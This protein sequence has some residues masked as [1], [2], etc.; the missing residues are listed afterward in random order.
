[1]TTQNG[2]FEEEDGRSP[3]TSVDLDKQ[4]L[5]EAD[6][7]Q[8][9]RARPAFQQVHSPQISSLFTG[10]F[11]L[12]ILLVDCC[13]RLNAQQKCADPEL[14][15]E[16]RPKPQTEKFQLQP[17]GGLQESSALS[18]MV[19]LCGDSVVQAE[20]SLKYAKSASGFYRATAQPDVHWKMVLPLFSLNE[21][22]FCP[23]LFSA[24][25]PGC[26]KCNCASFGHII[27]GLGKSKCP[28]GNSHF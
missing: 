28:K 14:S 9:A 4:F 7:L 18:A 16:P 22:C 15:A 17:R 8:K 2:Q 20:V 25:T 13:R 12:K 6:W 1:M 21:I 19:C 10:R 27:Q 26:L 5:A 23:S 11:Q 3:T 24:T